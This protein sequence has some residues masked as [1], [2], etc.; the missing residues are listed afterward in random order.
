MAIIQPKLI[1][2][3]EDRMMQFGKTKQIDPFVGAD[4]SRLAHQVQQIALELIELEDKLR[5][6]GVL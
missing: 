3:V 5:K 6:K 2:E 4:I 1:K